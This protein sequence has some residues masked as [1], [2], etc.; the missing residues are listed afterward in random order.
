ARTGREAGIDGPREQAAFAQPSGLAFDGKN[1]YVADSEISSIRA[2]NL[3]NGEVSTI[4]GSRDLFG[5]DDK[6]GKGGEARFQHPLGVEFNDGLLYAADTYNHKVKVIDPKDWT[7]KTLLGNAKLGNE[8]GAGGKLYEPGG[9]S[10]VDDKLYIADTNNHVIRVADLKTKEV[11]TL[12]ITGL[13]A[14]EVA[15][16]KSLPNRE[17]I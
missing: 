9:L 3:E 12:K 16:R 5:F 1:L 6:D 8:D 4:A 15:V 13:T 14:P 2:I 17:D 10:A 7:T 11:K